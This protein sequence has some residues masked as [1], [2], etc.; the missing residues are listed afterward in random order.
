MAERV[1][2]YCESWKRPDS[3]PGIEITIGLF[4]P[5]QLSFYMSVDLFTGYYL[6]IIRLFSL[7][8]LTINLSFNL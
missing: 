3:N 1:G 5:L 4:Y 2:M 8:I 7:E 6:E